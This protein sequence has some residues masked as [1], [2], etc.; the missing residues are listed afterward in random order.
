MSTPEDILYACGADS[1]D[2]PKGNKFRTGRF[3]GG[4]AVRIAFYGGFGGWQV[5]FSASTR[6]ERMGELRR[7]GVTTAV[8]APGDSTLSRVALG[9]DAAVIRAVVRHLVSTAATPR[10][11]EPPPE[12]RLPDPPSKTP[13]LP[14]LGWPPADIRSFTD[15]YTPAECA[16]FAARGFTPAEVR[17]LLGM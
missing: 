14:G 1:V 11:P 13:S 17:A 3:P 10:P 12:R 16:E 5:E 8:P 6:D 7:A 15:V 4:R 9:Q 2:P